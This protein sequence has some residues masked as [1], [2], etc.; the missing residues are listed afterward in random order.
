MRFEGF[1]KRFLDE[2]EQE[3]AAVTDAILS[4]QGLSTYEEYKR[5]IGRRNGLLQAKTRYEE[6]V[7][8]MEQASD[9]E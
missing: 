5:L 3:I 1:H 4:A 9:R 6:L 8:L 7:T 2:M